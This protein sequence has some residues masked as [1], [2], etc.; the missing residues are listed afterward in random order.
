VRGFRRDRTGLRDLQVNQGI[1][2]DHVNDL[3]YVWRLGPQDFSYLDSTTYT[4]IGANALHSAISFPDAVTGQ[5]FCEKHRPAFWIK[6]NLRVTVWYTGDT[7]ST[8]NSRM[9][10]S[11]SAVAIGGNLNAAGTAFTTVSVPGPAVIGDE[12]SFTFTE[13]I[14]VDAGHR[15]IAIKVK[16]L[17]TDGADNYAGEFLLTQ[18]VAE[19]VPTGQQL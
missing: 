13:L 15:H 4:R 2:E 1:I 11:V 17:G 5:A 3:H 6:G 7:A 16:R 18:V 10:G 12:K 9:G 14:P 19:F 8:N